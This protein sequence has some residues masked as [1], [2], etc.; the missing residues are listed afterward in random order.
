MS[1]PY[2]PPPPTVNQVAHEN[3]A[4]MT[5][6]F[7]SYLSGRAALAK[8]LDPSRSRA[9]TI[10]AECKYP[11]TLNIND[12]R[13]MWLRN[14][15]AQRVVSSYSEEC[16]T[17]DPEVYEKEGPD[18]TPWDEAL[19]ELDDEFQLW[20]TLEELDVYSGIG[21]F[22]IMLIGIDD[23][24]EL[25]DPIEGLESEG[26]TLKPVGSHNLLYLKVFSEMHVQ[27][28]T[29]EQDK[30]N[31]RYGRP[32]L[33]S[34]TLNPFPQTSQ[35][36]QDN[37]QTGQQVQVHWTRVIHLAAEHNQSRMHSVYNHLLDLKKVGGGSAEMF[38]RG[39]FPGMSFEVDPDFI[40]AG[41]TIDP[42]KMREEF[43]KYSEGLQR[44]LALT[45]VTAKTL[46][47]QVVDPAPHVDSILR[48]ISIA[49]KIPKQILE[50]SESAVLASAQYAKAFNKRLNR[51]RKQY[52]TPHLIRATIDRFIVLGI[53][54]FVESY[55]VEWDDLNSSTEK[56]KA[57][58]SEIITNTL[59]KYI[60]GGVEGLV[61]PRMY[62][63][64]VMG[65]E[66]EVV[67]KILQSM[68]NDINNL[69]GD[70]PEDQLLDA[71]GNPI[72]STTTPAPNIQPG[73]TSPPMIRSTSTPSPSND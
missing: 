15:V 39:A 20:S 32:I 28:S 1:K 70:D 27:V 40:A 43:T 59:A 57:D 42:E 63:V 53:L 25:S 21:C 5:L 23:G 17:T 29:W 38:W 3:K 51:R 7:N 67:D 11:E 60:Q 14:G 10:D 18:E 2:V 69:I 58:L 44:Y 56:E 30:T 35:N 19:D 68:Q 16:W 41:A 45:G 72:A 64:E 8:E 49:K 4:L 47:P 26:K 31:P 62:L 48:L 50:G 55:H 33:Y 65:W 13:Y 36:S 46:S 34:V 66:E 6:V 71:N 9:I 37:Q 12:F 54:P 61:D 73:T 22:G 52:C 24:K